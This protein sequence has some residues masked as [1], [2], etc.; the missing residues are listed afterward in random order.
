MTPRDFA[1]WLQGYF[2]I[3]GSE[4]LTKEQIA[5]IDTDSFLLGMGFTILIS[6][7]LR[8]SDILTEVNRPIKPKQDKPP[9]RENDLRN[10]TNQ[11][12]AE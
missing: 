8:L 1:Y 2:E 11:Q 5:M 7:I 3:T 12:Q 9:K 6:I 10:N 4:E